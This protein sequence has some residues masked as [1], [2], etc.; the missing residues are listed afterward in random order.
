[1]VNSISPGI[2][3]TAQGQAELRG[4]SGA[5]MR[6]MV[7]GS[8]AGRLGGPGDIAHAVEFLLSPA[9]SFISGIDL[10][11]DGGAVAAMQTP[12]APN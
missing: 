3:D 12:P 6:A 9:A 10:L 5:R 4:E 11:V 7:D 8:N 1:M 2:I